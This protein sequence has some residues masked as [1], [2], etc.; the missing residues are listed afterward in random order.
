MPTPLRWIFPEPMAPAA[1]AAIAVTHRLG[2]PAV[3]AVIAR[4]GLI[5]PSVSHY[6]SPDVAELLPAGGLA[7]IDDACAAID[8]AIAKG[9]RIVVHG[10][11]DVDGTTGAALLT[12]YLRSRG[13]DAHPFI[14]LRKAGYGLTEESIRR[15]REEIG[16]GMILTVDCGTSSHDEAEIARS[17]GMEGGV[18][19]PHR[20]V[21]GKITAGIV[22]NPHMADDGYG[23]KGI[24]GVAV[25]YKMVSAL[26]GEQPTANLDLVALGTVADVMP[27]T[28]ENRI[29]V[30]AGLARLAHT[31][32]PG[33]AALMRVAGR[34]VPA[35]PCAHGAR[36]CAVCGKGRDCRHDV[37]HCFRVSAESISFDLAPRINAVGRMGLD[38]AMVVELLLADDPDR[39]DEI[40]AA[41]DR[42]NKE[43][44][45][46]TSRLTDEAIERADPDDPVIVVRME[47]FKGVAGLVAGRLASE[48]GRPAI[49][50]DPSGHGSARSVKGV[51]LLSILQSDAGDLVTAAGHAV[52]MGISGIANVDGLRSRMRARAWPPELSER[53]IEVDAVL[54]LSDIDAGI[55]RALEVMEPTGEQ[56]AAPVFAVRNVEVA[57]VKKMGD[58]RHARLTLKD[59]AEGTTREAV[60]FFAGERMPTVGDHLDVAVRPLLSHDPYGGERLELRVRDARPAG[61]GA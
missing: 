55:V 5:G 44:K 29:I 50:V 15:I 30:R 19:D 20:P 3:A 18:T 9:T 23:N 7:R 6:L 26:H 35:V 58:G 60:W 40:A 48:F 17:L 46:Q 2:H 43:R 38:P 45:A 52:A 22:V 25:G 56:N 51:D 14:P 39:A 34:S 31:S 28:G 16:A 21:E 57:R 13:G 59:P 4:R 10:D 36:S 27:L 37:P 53:T 32:R 61:G 54:V 11:Y 41:I 24:A 42:A 1:A 47:L 49:V 33:I 8:A 12:K